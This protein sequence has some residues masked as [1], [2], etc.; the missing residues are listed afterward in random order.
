MSLAFVR[1]TASEQGLLEVLDGTLLLKK[2]DSVDP[3]FNYSGIRGNSIA[4][5]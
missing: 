5:M 1:D 4:Q 2:S 3:D